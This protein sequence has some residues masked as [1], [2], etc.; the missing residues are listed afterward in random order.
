MFAGANVAY[1]IFIPNF[2]CKKYQ[3]NTF[4]VVRQNVSISGILML[5]PNSLIKIAKLHQIP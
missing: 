3:K 1:K 4:A 5:L 2:C